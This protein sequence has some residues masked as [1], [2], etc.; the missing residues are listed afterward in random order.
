MKNTFKHIVTPFEGE[1]YVTAE[2]C[3]DEA[4]KGMNEVIVSRLERALKQP[5]ANFWY[6]FLPKAKHFGISIAWVDQCG[7][8]NRINAFLLDM[9]AA[10]NLIKSL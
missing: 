5:D 1:R 9:D 6:D 10:K 7:D 8:H 2:I 3:S 4:G